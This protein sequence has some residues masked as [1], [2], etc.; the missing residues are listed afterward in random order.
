MSAAHVDDGWLGWVAAGA[1]GVDPQQLLD[2]TDVASLARVSAAVEDADAHD[3][4][5]AAASALHA[6]VTE[7]PFPAGNRAA[8]W[9]AAAMI[10]AE[11]GITQR[12][13]DGTVVRLV[14]DAERHA[15]GVA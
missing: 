1:V 8:G 9:M 14:D 10:L 5:T 2:E 7:R 6:V 15:V 3:A 12:I 4:W 13:P 11:A